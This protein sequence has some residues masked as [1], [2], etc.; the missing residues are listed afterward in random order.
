VRSNFLPAF[1]VGFLTGFLIVFVATAIAD[2]N[3][4]DGDKGNNRVTNL[5]WCSHSYNS[6]HAIESGLQTGLKAVEII[7]IKEAFAGGI[8][9]RELA[10]QYS[11][12]VSTIGDIIKGRH[13]DINPEM[14]TRYEG[15]A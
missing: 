9:V 10:E 2:V 1:I 15:V 6:H 13:R 12:H 8:G 14:P 5:E 11:R 7:A 4:I 3:H